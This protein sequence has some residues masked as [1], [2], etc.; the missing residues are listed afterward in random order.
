MVVAI[1][2]TCFLLLLLAGLV[3][4]LYLNLKVVKVLKDVYLYQVFEL[5]Q[6]GK[7]D[8]TTIQHLNLIQVYARIVPYIGL[9][10]YR[11]P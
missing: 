7:E 6:N 5:T 2:V 3:V 9:F 1:V 11:N 10:R 4:C 8:S